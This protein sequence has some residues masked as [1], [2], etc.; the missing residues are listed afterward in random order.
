MN[1]VSLARRLASS[2]EHD[3]AI[4]AL[5]RLARLWALMRVPHSDDWTEQW[6]QHWDKAVKGSSSL[7]AVLRRALMDE[8]TVA[9]GLEVGGANIDVEACYD[10]ISLLRL[11]HE[12][13]VWH[14]PPQLL[15]LSVTQYLGP[16][17]LTWQG[18]AHPGLI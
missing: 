11:L 9:L 14:Y 4:Q 6:A 1:P 12:G 5:T 15:A 16:R 8:A 2:K 10:N 13:E 7:Q 3:R 18:R 17:Q